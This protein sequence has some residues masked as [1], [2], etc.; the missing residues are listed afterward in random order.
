M[1]LDLIT[2][3]AIEGL[4]DSFYAKIRMDEEL[5][6]VFMRAIPSDWGPHL[7]T[8]RN[9]WSS[10]MLTSGRY[11]GN[12]VAVHQRIEGMELRLFDRWLTLFDQTCDELFDVSV[13][14]AFAPRR[15]ASPRKSSWLCSTGRTGSGH[16][17][18]RKLCRHQITLL[19]KRRSPAPPAASCAR[20]ADRFDPQVA[21]KLL[22]IELPV[23]VR[24][25]FDLLDEL[26]RIVDVLQK[27]D[28]GIAEHLI[29]GR[30][31]LDHRGHL[32]RI[33][34]EAGKFQL[35]RSP[36]LFFTGTH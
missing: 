11:K 24:L 19:R 14:A 36:N 33:R 31:G 22:P 8:M 23:L 10:V 15:A 18:R 28:P 7:A 4:V 32:L 27:A 9:F 21:G 6:P 1:N 26:A 35:H 12:P 3:V 29:E 25:V 5:G 2:E 13:A 30:R 16:K 17:A 34:C 20:L